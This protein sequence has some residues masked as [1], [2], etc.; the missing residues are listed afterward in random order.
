MVFDDICLNPKMYAEVHLDI[1][2]LLYLIFLSR[3]SV[4]HTSRD[5]SIWKGRE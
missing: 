5:P 2:S 3:V 4:F 1:L